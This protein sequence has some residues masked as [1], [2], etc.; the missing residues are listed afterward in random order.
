MFGFMDNKK[1]HKVLKKGELVICD[2]DSIY[3][4]SEKEYQY[5]DEYGEVHKYFQITDESIIEHLEEYGEKCVLKAEIEFQNR[6]KE[7][8]KEQH[9]ER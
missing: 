6:K 4:K 7:E 5:T 3:P 1:E 2:L 9:D 8:R